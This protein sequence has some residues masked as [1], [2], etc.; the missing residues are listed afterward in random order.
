MTLPRFP[1]GRRGKKG[2]TVLCLHCVGR[3]AALDVHVVNTA[4]G[5]EGGVHYELWV[6]ALQALEGIEIL[7][8]LFEM[9]RQT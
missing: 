7:Y 5:G 2:N 1:V 3:P 6:K 4:L 9:L 8:S